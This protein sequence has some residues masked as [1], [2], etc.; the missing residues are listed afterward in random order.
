MA[1]T[2]YFYGTLRVWKWW[3]RKVNAVPFLS[4][5]VW[6]NVL[7]PFPQLSD[8]TRMRRYERCGPG[9]RDQ[10]LPGPGWFDWFP[11]AWSP[12]FGKQRGRRKRRKASA[13]DQA[14][15]PIGTRWLVGI[16]MCSFLSHSPLAWLLTP[17]QASLKPDNKCPEE[18]TQTAWATRYPKAA[19]RKDP[20]SPQ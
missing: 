6:N 9:L 17:T 20:W 15:F 7:C 18:P 1:S 14:F 5:T 12:R 19:S 2:R 10:E 8:S 3:R 16:Q 4:F 11:K 13:D